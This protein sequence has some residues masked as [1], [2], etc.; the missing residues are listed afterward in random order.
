MGIAVLAQAK[1]I[2][3]LWKG[4]KARKLFKLMK[5]S[6]GKIKFYLRKYILRR[7]FRICVQKVMLRMKG[8]IRKLQKVCRRAFIHKRVLQ[9]VDKR[10]EKKRREAEERR[11]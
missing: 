1:H 11:R 4:F 5:K 9:E 10:I 7:R 6:M 3:R 2:Q 8:A